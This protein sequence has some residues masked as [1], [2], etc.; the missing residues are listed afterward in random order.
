MQT[1][2]TSSAQPCCAIGRHPQVREIERALYDRVPLR[3]IQATH[4]VQH[5]PLAL[6]ARGHMQPTPQ[7]RKGRTPPRKPWCCL[8]G[9]H[10]AVGDINARLTNGTSVMSVASAF[11]VADSTLHKHA[12]RHLKVPRWRPPRA[13]RNS[14][15]VEGDTAYLKLMPPERD[16]WVAID[17]A[18]LSIARAD[19]YTWCA[20]GKASHTYA[21]VNRGHRT[22]SLHRMLL[23]APAGL[24]VDHANGNTLDNRRVNLRL[25]TRYQ[26]AQNRH[27]VP[28]NSNTGVRNVH[29]KM[30]RGRPYWM[31]WIQ[32]MGKRYTKQFPYTPDGFEAACDW[33]KRKRAEVM[34]F[35]TT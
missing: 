29:R 4:R 22:I 19:G 2:H 3:R 28:P 23:N 26:N 30:T 12:R 33:A 31:V 13:Y 14:L 32:S 25:A 1:D 10:A 18:D 15:R 5:T 27:G 11:G 16:L 8:I 21:V 6:H 34:P 9:R 20:G 24:E 7:L 17:L 35:S